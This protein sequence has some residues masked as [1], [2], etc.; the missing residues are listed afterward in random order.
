MV[1]P[2][3]HHNSETLRGEIAY[4]RE[5]LTK[6]RSSLSSFYGVLVVIPL[7]A[8]YWVIRLLIRRATGRSLPALS[9][10]RTGASDESMNCAGSRRASNGGPLVRCSQ[11]G[12]YV[13]LS[14]GR[15]LVHN[16]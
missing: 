7:L 3:P 9:Y 5:Q 12:R 11:C 16:R 10:G 13:G 1:L 2:N 6:R 14:N 8:A 4:R 15:V